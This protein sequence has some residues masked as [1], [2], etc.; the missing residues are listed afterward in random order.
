VLRLQ[1]P[2][3]HLPEPVQ[4]HKLPQKEYLLQKVVSYFTTEVSTQNRE[5]CSKAAA[6]IG[7]CF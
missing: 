4:I 2:E 5:L 7:F 6:L 1:K 3:D